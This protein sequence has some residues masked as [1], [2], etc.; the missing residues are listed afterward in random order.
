MPSKLIS[1]LVPAAI[2]IFAASPALAAPNVLASLKPIHSLVAGV[3]EGV[4]EPQLLVQG[5]ASEHGYALRPSDAAKI[6]AAEVVFWVGPQME[7]YMTSMLDTLASDAAIVPLMET[8][9]LTLLE[10]REGGLFE[11]HSHGDEGHGHDHD[12]EGHDHHHDHDHADA[13]IW[14]DPENARAMVEAIVA[15]LSEVDPENADAYAENGAALDERLDALVAEID[16]TLEPARGAPFFVF[17]DAYHAFENRFDIE[18]TGSF[19]VNPEVAPGAGRLADISAVVSS[20]DAICLFA[21]PQFSP[22]VVESVAQGTGARLGTLDPLGAD[23][24]DGPDLYFALLGNL[25]TSLTDC[26]LD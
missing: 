6:E 14:L 16:A 13:H 20:S 19:T 26:L 17:H 12:H 5:A 11:P 2:A 7:T 21:E 18:A 9:G 4:G 24:A 15:T 23:I 22:Q 10:L 3:M 8:E 25:A 1:L